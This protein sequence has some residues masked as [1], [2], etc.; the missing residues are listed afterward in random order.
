[1]NDLVSYDHKHNHANLEDNRDGSN[2]NL[3][4]N[5]GIE[6][7]TDHP[8]VDK[9][10]NRQIK[11]FFTINLL[12]LGVPMLLM[13]DEVRHTQLGNNNAYCQDNE[14][15]WFDWSLPEK[16]ADIHHFVKQLINLRRNLNVLKQKTGMSLIDF[17]HQ[18][19]L[20]WHG[21]KLNHPDWG[22]HSHSLAFTVE[23][24]GGRCL[25]H[26]I[27]SAYWSPLEFEIPLGHDWHRIIDTYL[28]SP[29]DF[30]EWSEAPIVTGSTYLV[31]ARS[32]VLLV[33]EIP[34]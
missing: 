21:A 1:M 7:A 26:V 8:D 28:E 20:E 13:G 17:L 18:A 6:G 12:A 30:C 16:Q 11:N 5:C 22:Y 29:H 3:S 10:R 25:F 4:W 2:N 14:I 34:D 23:S 27:F 19:K 32:T 15:S 33:A 24:C 31:N 9:L